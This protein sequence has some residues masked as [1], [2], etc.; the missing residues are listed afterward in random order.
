MTNR[1][2]IINSFKHIPSDLVP[3][4]LRMETGIVAKLN[5]YYGTA[6]WQNKIRSYINWLPVVDTIG[7]RDIKN[8]RQAD[9]YGSIWIKSPHGVPVQEKPA[10]DVPSLKNYQ[11]PASSVFT[12]PLIEKIGEYKR[13]CE[14]IGR[15]RLL[16]FSWG[17]FEQ[18]WAIRGFENMLTD[19]LI[20]QEF[21]GELLGRLAENFMAMLRACRDIPA[22]GIM[23]A[24]D[25]GMQTGTIVSPDL[26]RKFFKPHW[27][28]IADEIHGQKK[29]L[30][31]HCCGSYEAL[32]PDA[33]ELGIDC[34]ESV[35]P[36]AFNMNPYKLKQKYGKDISFWGCLGNQ[37]IIQFG[38]PEKIREEIHHLKREM[39]AGGGYILAA[40]KA[41]QAETPVEN[42]A[43]V[44]EAFT[45]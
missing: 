23:I 2:A 28:I 30:I 33:V 5:D 41:I 25:W 29:D 45:E 44:Y 20:E 3:Y 26:W 37:S 18:S 9:A 21:Y 39:S 40:A 43:A 13:Q 12:N 22:D 6:D 17:L 24:E 10:L 32:L 27:K 8:G 14:D 15:Y 11:W 38:T 1:Q 7:T 19:I 36:E 34:M 16:K 42:A 4:S 31:V 35:Q